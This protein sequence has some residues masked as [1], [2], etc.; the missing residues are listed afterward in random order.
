MNLGLRVV[1]AEV[2]AS[3]ALAAHPYRMNCLYSKMSIEGFYV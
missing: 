3:I 1:A 2:L